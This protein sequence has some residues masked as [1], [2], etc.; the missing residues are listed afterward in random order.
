MSL[1]PASLIQATD[2]DGNPVSGAKWEFTLTGTSTP[3]NVYSNATLATSLGATVT[4][5]SA[6]WFAPIYYDDNVL[7]RAVLKTPAGATIG[8]HDID[9]INGTIG[10]ASISFLQ[11][12]TGAVTRTALAKMR[13]SVTAEDF[14]V[15]A[16]ESD[17]KAKM[18]TGLIAQRVAGGGN[19]KLMPGKTYNVSSSGATNMGGTVDILA[20]IGH[21]LLPPVDNVHF[22]GNGGYLRSVAASQAVLGVIAEFERT[23]EVTGAM[24]VGAATWT[25]LTAG[26]AAN[27]AVGNDVFWRLED[28]PTDTPEPLNWGHAKVLSVN[29][30]TNTVTLDRVLHRAWDGTDT[31]NKHIQKLGT[32]HGQIIDNLRVSGVSVNGS[33][34]TIGARIQS[35][36]TPRI[37]NMSVNGA[38][39][40]VYVQFCEGARFGRVVLEKAPYTG[41]NTGQGIR[42]AESS[43]HIESLHTRGVE[44]NALLAESACDVTV[45]YHEDICLNPTASRLITFVGT[46]SRVHIERALYKGKGDCIAFDASLAGAQISYGHVRY[47]KDMHEKKYP[48]PGRDCQELSLEI[49]GVK[50]LYRA[51]SKINL[52]PLLEAGNGYQLEYFRPGVVSRLVVYFGGGL[53]AADISSL[54]I[55]YNSGTNSIMSITPPAAPTQDPVDLT[56]ALGFGT[57]AMNSTAFAQRATN[58]NV[59]VT[60]A[61]DLR[62]TGKFLLFDIDI[63]P[64]ALDTSYL[65]GDKNS[66]RK[67]HGPAIFY[68]QKTYDAPSIAAGAQTSTTVTVTGASVGDFVTA[69]ALGVSP[70]GL[71]KTSEV[72]AADT[73]TVWLDNNTAGAIDLAST[74]LSVKVERR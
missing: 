57:T 46:N 7:C 24:A 17:S 22:D 5:D 36:V 12:G 40:G 72:T 26:V 64:D 71:T 42:F 48:L 56:A 14:G 25:F 27:Y 54:N 67:A 45:G 16:G 32:S 6:G 41:L 43:A 20:G 9:P 53:V 39:I 73:V 23:D 59:Q 37:P 28:N 19:F 13:E 30:G 8:G 70:A 69:V 10:A 52:T 4:A 51:A 11:A 1:F 21:L 38:K 62:G 31:N 29:T 63:I 34:E 66:I 3:T 35:L 2:N 47:E 50:E 15:V 55:M 60:W 18:H 49:A 74:T 68:G 65:F 33:T 61:S 44:S 58:F